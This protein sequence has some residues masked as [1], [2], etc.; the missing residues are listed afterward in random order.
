MQSSRHHHLAELDA[1]RFVLSEMQYGKVIVPN[2]LLEVQQL[3]VAVDIVPAMWT[4]SV[5]APWIDQA[6]L[7]YL[8]VAEWSSW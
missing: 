3:A 1:R 5:G 8:E 7:F 2:A 6:C 4:A